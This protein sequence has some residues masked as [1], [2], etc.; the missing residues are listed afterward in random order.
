MLNTTS[1]SYAKINLNLKVLEKLEDEEY[2]LIESD[3]ALLDLHSDLIFNI[4]K[5]SGFQNR[6]K[7]IEDGKNVDYEPIK[8]IINLWTK[9]RQF[10]IDIN[11]EIKNPMPIMAGLGTLS[12]YAASTLNVLE[13][14]Y[15]DKEKQELQDEVGVEVEKDLTLHLADSLSI[16][17]KLSLAKAVGMDTIF[18]TSGLKKAHVS[19]KGEILSPLKAE[20]H[21]VILHYPD[22]KCST[23]EA[24]E[25]LDKEN[26]YSFIDLKRNKLYYEMLCKKTGCTEWKLTGSGSTFFIYNPSK[27][28]LKKTEEWKNKGIHFLL[29]KTQK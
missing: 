5:S 22:Y 4:K 26:V 20:E 15:S 17:P 9:E 6:I 3:I 28:I 24:Y 23:K 14:F 10:S 8:N 29:T 21:T 2:H 11:I 19:G 16:Y 1:K 13:L 18:F 27:D 12:S 7:I 25:M